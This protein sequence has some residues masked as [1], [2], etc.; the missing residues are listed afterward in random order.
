[1]T[2]LL[3]ANIRCK[4]ILLSTLLLLAAL[5]EDRNTEEG[6]VLVVIVPLCQENLLAAVHLRSRY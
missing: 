1:V 2:L 6:A 4:H 5:Q 3:A